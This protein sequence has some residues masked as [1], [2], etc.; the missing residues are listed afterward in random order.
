MAVMILIKTVLRRLID[1]QKAKARESKDDPLE[2][3]IPVS[4]K[5]LVAE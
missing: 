2:L 1:V 3:R 5:A 4:K